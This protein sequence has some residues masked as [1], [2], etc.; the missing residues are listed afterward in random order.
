MQRNDQHIAH[1]ATVDSM[2]AAPCCRR[3][4]AKAILHRSDAHFT[5]CCIE[6]CQ[7]TECASADRQHSIGLRPKSFRPFCNRGD[8]RQKE[9]CRNPC[10]LVPVHVSN[11]PTKMLLQTGQCA[12]HCSGNGLSGEDDSCQ[13]GVPGCSIHSQKQGC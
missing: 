6:P 10:N 3:R 5:F 7:C 11:L 13:G 9:D 12:G 4:P 8:K 1:D 2:H